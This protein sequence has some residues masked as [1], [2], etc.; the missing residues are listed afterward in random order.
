MSFTADS[1]G[2]SYKHSIRTVGNGF[3]LPT[4]QPSYNG[5][6]LFSDIASNLNNH[7]INLLQPYI[8]V[9]FWHRIS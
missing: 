5:K 8:A 1:I 2:G 3:G 7:D 6:I 4:N 9:Y